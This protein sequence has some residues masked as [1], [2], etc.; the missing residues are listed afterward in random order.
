MAEQTKMTIRVTSSRTA[1]TVRVST[2]GTY[3]GAQT[4]TIALDLPAQPVYTTATA[5]A[6]WLAVLATVTA[7]I[8]GLP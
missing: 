5:K 6:F 4:N 7:E 3:K 1:S 8:E 2:A